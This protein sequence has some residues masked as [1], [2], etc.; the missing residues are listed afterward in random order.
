MTLH[1]GYKMAKIKKVGSM[2][3]YHQ[4]LRGMLYFFD[5]LCRKNNIKY[6][7]LDGTLLGAVRNGGF[8]PWDGDVDVAV[9]WKQFKKL[10]SAFKKYNGRFYLNYAPS[11]FYK[12][13][14]FKR[15]F[16]SICA[17][18]IDKKSDN[19]LFGIDV[20]TID[21][22]GDDL[23]YAE[24][25]LKQYRMLACRAKASISFHLPSFSE[26]KSL[27]R[28]LRIIPF[29]VFYPVLKL[30]SMIYIPIW[31]RQYLKFVKERL[32]YDEN[33]RYYT[34]Q[35]YLGRIGVLEN[36]ILSNGYMDIK[37]DNMTVMA[38]KN[39]DSYLVPTYH[40]YMKLPPEEKRIPFPSEKEL[41]EIHIEMDEELSRYIK[42]AHENRCL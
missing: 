24:D 41:M 2:N 42:E 12:R 33:S 18:V 31:N 7:I 27:L 6:T 32:K 36:D 30:I 21:F 16:G 34:I 37:F 10:K 40:D 14:G 19:Q 20:F 17:K 28:N 9:T 38:V 1:G 22:L 4:Y 3:E 35:P 13:K 11:H 15:A 5:D 39:Y 25:T 23:S 8:I 26:S 29:F